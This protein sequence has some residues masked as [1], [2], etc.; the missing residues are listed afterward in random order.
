[1]LKAGQ[2]ID[3]VITDIKLKGALTGWD[4]AD[5]FR[6]VQP[7]MPVIYASAQAILRSCQGFT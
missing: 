3:I 1:M 7:T 4:V 5:A 6:A 2:Q